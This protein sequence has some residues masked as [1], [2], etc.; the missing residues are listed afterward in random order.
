MLMLIL[1]MGTNII[2]ASSRSCLWSSMTSLKIVALP[3]HLLDLAITLYII[4]FGNQS[5]IFIVFIIT[6][7]LFA[8]YYLTLLQ[9]FKTENEGKKAEEFDLRSLNSGW[10]RGETITRPSLRA[11][12]GNVLTITSRLPDRLGRT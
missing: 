10:N 4:G 5:G 2:G 6:V 12:G 9:T 8:I 1:G 11:M 3:R 7:G